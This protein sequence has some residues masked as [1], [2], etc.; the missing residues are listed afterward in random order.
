MTT[1]SSD[2]ARRNVASAAELI[3]TKPSSAPTE[4]SGG[5]DLR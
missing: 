1:N 3:A 4:R 5:G 2:R